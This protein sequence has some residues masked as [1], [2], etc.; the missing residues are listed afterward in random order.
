MLS[1]YFYKKI[2]FTVLNKI[3]YKKNKIYKQKKFTHKK[4]FNKQKNFI[5]KKIFINKKKFTKNNYLFITLNINYL[6]YLIF[7]SS[8]NVLI[9]F[10]K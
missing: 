8:Y 4:K 7:T 5:N 9:M 1:I 10:Y 3:K 2:N 6:S